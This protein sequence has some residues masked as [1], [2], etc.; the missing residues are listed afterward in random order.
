MW[1]VHYLFGRAVGLR[2]V[3]TRP[4][5]MTVAC[6]L[7]DQGAQVSKIED[8]GGL[9]KSMNAAEIRLMHVET[10]KLLN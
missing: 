4:L 6:E 2:S 10:Q 3:G 8:S 1:H 5:A 7:L 9:I